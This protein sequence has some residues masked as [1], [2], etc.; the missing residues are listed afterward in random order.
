MPGVER[1]R[2]PDDINSTG[3]FPPPS[4]CGRGELNGGV[5]IGAVAVA[6]GI[7]FMG[8]TLLSPLYVLYEQAFAFS[9]TVLTLIY[10]VYAIGNVAALLFFGRLSDEIGRRRVTHFANALAAL[11]TLLFLIADGTS[12]LF[13]AR[14][15]SGFAIGA[16]AGTTTAWL[17]ELYSARNK[18]GATVMASGAN[19][20]GVA[21]GP[22]L[23]GFL[24]QYAPWPLH[25]P[26]VIYLLALLVNELLIWQAPETVNHPIRSF[27]RISLRPRLGV[28]KAIRVRFVAPAVTVFVTMGLFGFYV[29]L[30][31]IIVAENLHQPNRAVGGLVVFELLAVAAVAIVATQRVDSRT[32]M[33]GALV[34]LLP[35]IAL[36]VLAQA[37][38]SVSILLIGTSLGGISTA[39]GYRGSLQVVNQIAPDSRRAEVVSSYFVC[40][41]CGNSL[42]VIGVGVISS[43]WTPLAASFIFAFTIVVLALVALATGMKYITKW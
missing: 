2:T 26:F 31:P 4:A 33:L 19:M 20:V 38:E 3:K 30:V 16:G 13:A 7:F 22:L 41:F 34:L 14:L 37:L 11:S 24:A 9:R 40:G 5:A 42:P 43:I 29:A 23:A 12:W 28:P 17:V 35:S 6:L 32:S 10:A 18:S 27:A 21:V 1:A 8:S 15:L 25:L 36:L 39:L